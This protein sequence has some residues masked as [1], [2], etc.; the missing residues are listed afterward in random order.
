[1]TFI[2]VKFGDNKSEIFNPNCRNTSL[3]DNIKER[4]DCEKDDWISLSD[5]RGIL[6]KIHLNLLDYASNYLEPRGVF[7]LIK[8]EKDENSDD[9]ELTYTPL[10][11]SLEQDQK[12]L[13]R[14]RPKPK[15]PSTNSPAKDKKYDLKRRRST[16]V[17]V[18]NSKPRTPTT[19]KGRQSRVQNYSLSPNKG[20][21]KGK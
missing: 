11:D 8:I 14:L 18:T 12:F 9:H 2:T 17:I 10:L 19:G 16:R 13:A 4:C 7:I 1:M 6:K 5:E 20:A 3:I 21:K 15:S